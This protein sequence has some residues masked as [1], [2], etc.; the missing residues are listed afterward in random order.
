MFSCGDDECKTGEHKEDES[1]NI[2]TKRKQK[3]WNE[4][5]EYK[6]KTSQPN[7]S[8]TLRIRIFLHF[9][10]EITVRVSTTHF[11][12]V[13]MNEPQD[14]F[15]SVRVDTREIEMKSLRPNIFNAHFFY[16]FVPVISFHLFHRQ[17]H[18]RARVCVAFY[19]WIVACHNFMY[20]VDCMDA[21][22]CV[23]KINSNRCKAIEIYWLILTLSISKFSSNDV[24]FLFFFL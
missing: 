4:K 24:F 16:F 23:R 10:D 11:G 8:K 5:C 15:L 7:D 2:K 20:I 3:I 9:H 22:V 17:P 19:L 18:T 12:R 6:R 1:I 14:F 13:S 21:C